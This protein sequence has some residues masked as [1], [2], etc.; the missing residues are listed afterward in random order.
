LKNIYKRAFSVYAAFKHGL[1]VTRT[2]VSSDPNEP[3]EL[4]VLGGRKFVITT[5]SNSN[6]PAISTADCGANGGGS[7]GSQF[8]TPELLMEYYE[9]LDNHP[10][11]SQD[12]EMDEN[13]ATSGNVY[14][15]VPQALENTRTTEHI[16]RR[17]ATSHTSPTPP[18]IAVGFDP[19][20]T[21]YGQADQRTA[22]G[23][24]DPELSHHRN[25]HP[26]HISHEAIAFGGSATP[27]TNFPG[28]CRNQAA[29]WSSFMSE[30]GTQT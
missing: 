26:S 22:L 5:K 9:Q 19:G 18:P 10:G 25:I 14:P 17:S 23:S 28:Q 11:T 8:G 6:S 4:E 15:L 7:P 2:K 24:F 16:G 21:P 12:F 3:D 13:N 20:H 1:G 30:F 27:P 29:I